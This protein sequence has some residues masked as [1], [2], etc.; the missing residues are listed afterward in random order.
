MSTEQW[1]LDNADR[2]RQYRRDHYYKNKEQY[3]G[4]NRKAKESKQDYIRQ[5]KNK[6][7]MD[8]NE[9]YPHYV[10]D[11][12]H[13]DPDKKLWTIATMNTR[14]WKQIKEE[15]AKCDVVCSNCHRERTHKYRAA[16]QPS[17]TPNPAD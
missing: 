9:S 17:G 14:T 12:D 8:C 3:F 15:I 2:M 11:F 13:R 16:R 7:C 10:M 4:R 6:P 1:K 5:A